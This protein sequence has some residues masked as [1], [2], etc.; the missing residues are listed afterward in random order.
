MSLGGGYVLR[1]VEST[2]PKSSEV[3]K[4][5]PSSSKSETNTNSNKTFFYLQPAPKLKTGD[6]GSLNLD[7][8]PSNYV[9]CELDKGQSLVP[10]DFET[11]LDTLL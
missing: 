9:F 2:L 10:D 4:K 8:V 3:Y 6:S 5:R 1:E 7:S 11:Y